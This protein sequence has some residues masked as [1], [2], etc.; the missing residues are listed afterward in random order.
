MNRFKIA[1]VIFATAL[2]LAPAVGWRPVSAATATAN[3]S[4]SATVTNNC[5]IGTSAVAFGGYD[6]IATHAS[7]PLDASGTVT[8]TCTQGTTRT[9]GLSLGANATGATRR[10]TDGSS[11][12]VAYELFKDSGRSSIWGNSGAD[13]LTPAVDPAASNAAV[14]LTVYGRI[15][16]G[17]NVVAGSYTDTVVATV[18]F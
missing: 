2:V 18:T 8:V 6:P 12:Y 7:T 9:V 1:T 15:A 4:V 5:T 13:L 17:Q 3:L 16:A 11:H 10:L 14:N